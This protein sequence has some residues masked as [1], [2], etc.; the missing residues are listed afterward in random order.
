MFRP[1][2]ERFLQ[3]LI[4]T[5]IAVVAVPVHGAAAESRDAALIVDG[6]TGKV[7]YE[8]NADA[9]RYPASLT[10]MMTL[11]LLFDA[12]EEKRITLDTTI[13]ASRHSA[14]Q[15]PTK[16]S[17]R[18]GRTI[19]VETA[20]EALVVRS[21]NDVAV[22]VAEALGGS[23][24]NF[25]KMMTDAAHALGMRNTTFKNASGLPNSE[26]RTTASDMAL[27]GRRL[28]YDFPQ[29]Y[30]YL[31]A[32]SFRY[33]GQRYNGHNNVLEQYEGA[34]GI[35]TGFIRLSGFNLVTSAIRDNTH[36][37]GVV[38]GGATAAA[39]DREMM[40]LLDQHF[41]K[42]AADRSYTA[43]ANVPWSEEPGRKTIAFYTKPE[44][45]SMVSAI[46]PTP[47][48][49]TAPFALALAE[50]NEAETHSV[51]AAIGSGRS[52]TG[53]EALIAFNSLSKA[54][55]DNG[56]FL[57]NY[58]GEGDVSYSAPRGEGPSDEVRVVTSSSLYVVQI[59]TF[60][61]EEIAMSRLNSYQVTDAAN[62][63]R[64]FIEQVTLSDGRQG[65]G[66]R[67]GYFDEEEARDLCSRLGEKRIACEL[68]RIGS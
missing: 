37:V 60:P 48:P 56:I 65:F 42:A 49:G 4:F 29:Y 64:K 33:A 39:R 17:V 63:A 10:K 3:A 66:A 46:M 59:G 7:L 58:Y 5:L 18:A 6:V 2:A 53:D 28:A 25:A 11:Y 41:D 43:W 51:L 9:L 67:L 38:M 20:I 19:T 50:P 34:D 62:G 61:N 45:Y 14:S 54:P 24:E 57:G 27:L 44:V 31:S 1:G 68:A 8:R 15:P 12:L 13:I 52:R 21:A 40:A 16:L 32:T 26:Q 23:E 35:K 36:L 55:S 30:H 47:K 22:M